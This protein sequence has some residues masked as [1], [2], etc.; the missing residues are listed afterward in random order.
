MKTI[1]AFTIHV[2]ADFP[3]KVDAAFRL[4]VEY[5]QKFKRDVMVDVIGFRRLGHNEHDSPKFTQPLLYER[6]DN[7]PHLASIYSEYLVKSGFFSQDEID[8]KYKTIMEQLSQAYETAKAGKWTEKERGSS[9]WDSLLGSFADCKNPA[10]MDTNVSEEIFRKVGRMINE[11]PEGKSYHPITQK[12]YEA[13]LKSVESGKGIDW[14]TAEALAFGSLLNLG[15]GVRVSGEDVKRGTFS[16]RHA[17][18]FDQKTGENVLPLNSAALNPEGPFRFQIY[19]SFLSEYGVLG[20]DYGYSNG[21]PNYLTIW[22]AQF[23]DFANVAQPV[24]DT[25]ICNGENKWRLKSGLVLLLPHGL[26]GQGPEHSSSKAERY[27]QMLN[28]DIYDNEFIKDDDMQLRLCN[29]SV[30]NITDP[31]NYFHILRRQILRDY[32]K[33]LII[34]A[35]KRLLRLKEVESS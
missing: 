11:L 20:F 15:Y 18:L 4:A 12:V 34:C 9:I 28:D 24:I 25:Y 19:N 3:E 5:R 2:N 10:G 27:L 29:Y 14:P 35:P 23:G 1:N 16:H 7:K 22:E 21:N 33:P 17:V 13:R 8:R 26:D 32:R 30:C 6:I 31:A